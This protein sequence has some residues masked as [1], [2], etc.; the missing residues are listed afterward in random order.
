[1]YIIACTTPHME[2]QQLVPPTSLHQHT[3][4]MQSTKRHKPSISARL[5]VCTTTMLKRLRTTSQSKP[6]PEQTSAGP[7]TQRA[8]AT[9]QARATFFG[10]PSELRIAIY[11]YVADDVVLSMRDLKNAKSANT[12][13]LL[14]VCRQGR[15]EYLSIL[16]ATATISI[17]ITDMNFDDLLAKLGRLPQTD[18]K[19]LSSNPNLIIRLRIKKCDS[20]AYLNLRR[21]CEYCSLSSNPS[22]PPFSPS[23][24]HWL[25]EIDPSSDINPAQLQ[26]YC[27]RIMLM[28]ERVEDEAV[29]AEARR[30]NDALDRA[31]LGKQAL[32]EWSQGSGYGDGYALF[33]AQAARRR[34]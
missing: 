19:A 28:Q 7:T 6:E 1:M 10:L 26:W 29:V 16:L 11:E 20:K 17:I 18:V 12:S 33:A 2:L 4:Y 24:L 25:Y 23:S 27:G 15:E 32:G 9:Q 34:G 31:R 5:S 3:R 21:W 8:R 22:S 13:S 30:V 14:L